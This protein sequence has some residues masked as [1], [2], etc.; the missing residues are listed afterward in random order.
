MQLGPSRAGPARSAALWT[1]IPQPPP[2]PATCVRLAAARLDALTP[3]EVIPAECNTRAQASQHRL[4]VKVENAA[5]K[6]ADMQQLLRVK[7]R[8]LRNLVL[9][10]VSTLASSQPRHATPIVRSTVAGC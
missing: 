8:W 4:T 2:S 3:M 1:V 7:A 6:V 5:G 9:G 10:T